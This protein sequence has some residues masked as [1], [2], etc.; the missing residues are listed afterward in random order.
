VQQRRNGQS[1]R[2]LLHGRR[3]V[4]HHSHMHSYM[5]S[6]IH[7][8]LVYG[9]WSVLFIIHTFIYSLL[10]HGRRSVPHRTAPHRVIPC[11]PHSPHTWVL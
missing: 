3:S 7:S 5:H 2:L 8:L 11:Y 10:L 4:L 6:F 1:R 9:C